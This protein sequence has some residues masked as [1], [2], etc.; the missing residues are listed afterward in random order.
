MIIGRIEINTELSAIMSP[1]AYTPP[2]P[3]LLLLTHTYFA[4]QIHPD[5]S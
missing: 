1:S 4:N 2:R 5:A 3:M